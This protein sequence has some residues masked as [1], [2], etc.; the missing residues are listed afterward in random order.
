MNNLDRYAERGVSTSKAG[1]HAAV[2]GDDKGLFPT[3]FCRI[4]PDPA[5]TERCVV[6]HGDGVGTK[7]ILPYLA[8]RE[9][10]VLETWKSI[11][12]NSIVMN[13]DDVACVGAVKGPFMLINLINRNPFRIPDNVIAAILE[14]DREFRARMAQWEISI[15]SGGGET[16]DVPDPA[17]LLTIDH[18]LF[19]SMGRADVID[20]GRICPG[21]IIVGFSSTG[22][23]AWETEPDS[24]MGS[25]GLTNARH[26]VL[27][28]YYK[29][30]YPE[31]LAP[32]MS[33]EKAYCG[34]HRL[35][36]FLP[37]D[38]RFTVG[39]ALM[40][41][42]RTYLPLVRKLLEHV[43]HDCVHGLIHCS[44]GG[45]VKIGKFGRPGN[46]YIKDS[47]FPIPPLFSF[48][49]EA[50]GLPWREMYTSYNCGWRL[51]ACV[52]S[53]YESA[54]IFAANESGIDARRVGYVRENSAP[55]KEVHISTPGGWEVYRER[56]HF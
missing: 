15:I 18:A 34:S 47:P 43:P 14:G 53:E 27:S 19:T 6:P 33:D 10:G 3:A 39:S 32:E 25:N 24:G 52:P 13:L 22:Q 23:A 2:A 56:K 16:A 30:K 4:L 55:L 50:R 21:D 42:T 7:L 38:T 31:T 28:D 20:A 9:G 35:D 11:S 5:N 40:S 41:P 17:R 45:Q 36:E 46:V 26:D 1:I 51:E 29:R 44:G 8:W 37:G 12:Q 48:L 49:Q 54:C